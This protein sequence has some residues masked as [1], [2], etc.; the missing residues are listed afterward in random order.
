MQEPECGF[1]VTAVDP[2]AD[3]L[4]IEIRDYN[5]RFAGSTRIYAGLDNL[6]RFAG[7]IE[8]FPT[9]HLD[10]RAYE[11][12]TRDPS[13]AGGYCSVTLSCLDRAGHVGVEVVL[14]DDDGRYAPAPAK[15]SFRTEPAAI[16]RFVERLRRVEQ[17][18]SGS[19]VLVL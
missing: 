4:G 7:T 1:T 10:S 17:E 6:S 2:D 14:E 11:F 9:G 18:R 15:F 16:D 13:F 3:Y 12:G 5:E 8:G 19:A